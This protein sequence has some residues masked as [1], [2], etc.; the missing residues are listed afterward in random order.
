MSAETPLKAPAARES[1][2][3]HKLGPF[4][5]FLDIVEEGWT[6][7]SSKRI[8][9]TESLPLKSG[10]A[11]HSVGTSTYNLHTTFQLTH[12]RHHHRTFAA[13]LRLDTP[14]LRPS[15][16]DGRLSA[17]LSGVL[18]PPDSAASARTS[19]DLESGAVAVSYGLTGNIWHT[20]WSK[21]VFHCVALLNDVVLQVFLPSL[22]RRDTEVRNVPRPRGLT[23]LSQTRPCTRSSSFKILLPDNSLPKPWR[24][25]QARLA[26]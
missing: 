10:I 3:R 4:V 7:Q 25:L 23:K 16:L 21:I 18:G 1:G 14:R 26:P 13:W 9:E 5:Q 12:F 6:L 8:C 2:N 17:P 11:A 24:Y 19:A 22:L 15:L 20:G